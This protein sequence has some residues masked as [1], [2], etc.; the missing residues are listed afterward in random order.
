MRR[1]VHHPRQPAADRADQRRR[2]RLADDHPQGRGRQ[3]VPRVPRAAGAG[4][5]SGNRDPAGRPRAPPVL[6]GAGDAL[7]GARHRRPRDRLLRADRRRATIEA[8]ASSTCPTSPRRAGTT[9]PGDIRTA[10]AHLRALPNPPRSIFTTGFCM[11]GRLASMSTTL[12]LGL[13]GAI[14]FY[15]WPAGQNRNGTPAPAEVAGKIE[16]DLLLFYGEKRRGH[17]EGRARHVRQGARQGGREARD[18]RLPGR[19]ARLLR[20]ALRGARGCLGRCLGQDLDV[21]PPP[22]AGPADRR[23]QPAT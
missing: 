22:H 3:G 12:G 15:G 18:D 19:A 14:P 2:H 17:H 21:H 1:H 16:C 8:R 7:R 11:G 10:V 20:S 4:H 5:G 6:R 9:S 13:A 23:H